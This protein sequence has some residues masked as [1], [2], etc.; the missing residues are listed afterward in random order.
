MASPHFQNDDD[1]GDDMQDDPQDSSN[2]QSKDPLGDNLQD[3]PQED[4]GSND[5]PIPFDPLR[6]QDSTSHFEHFFSAGYAVQKPVLSNLNRLDFKHL[7]LAGV[8]V[9]VSPELQMKILIP[10]R[11]NE[12]RVMTG[13]PSATCSKTTETVRE[14]KA[15]HGVH[16]DGWTLRGRQ[17]LW[18]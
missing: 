7:L 13:I 4:P 5:S 14:I 3:D 15:C 6:G 12:L 8:R 16:H 10:S 17:E 11:C 18:D 2:S 1:M 9:P